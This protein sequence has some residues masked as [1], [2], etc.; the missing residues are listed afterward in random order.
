MPPRRLALSSRIKSIISF[1]SNKNKRTV[2][3][4]SRLERDALY[5]LE[6]DAS[7]VRYITQ[8]ETFSYQLHG[9]D[10][11]YTPD[12]LVEYTDGRFEYIEVK[13]DKKTLKDSF[14]AKFGILQPLFG[15]HLKTPLRI[16]KSSAI[17]ISYRIPNY[18]R[19]YRYRHLTFP[20]SAYAQLI[21]HYPDDMLS[22]QQLIRHC[23]QLQLPDTT[24]LQLLAHQL[25]EFDLDRP[26]LPET[27]LRRTHVSV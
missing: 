1:F 11:V 7:V 27:P 8:P 13:P 22:F 25:Y 2:Y 19:L 20:H 26:L 6:F 21:S 4:E 12:I 10:R 3:T 23:Q 16:W 17:Q 24:S 18:Q 5:H 15:Q 9:K 14:I